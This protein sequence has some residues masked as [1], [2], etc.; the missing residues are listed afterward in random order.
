MIT[1][2]IFDLGAVVLS[3]DWHYDCQEKFDDF[4]ET[5]EIDYD[6]MERGWENHAHDYVKGKM[7]EEEFWERFLKT[8]G[9]KKI[10][11]EL[12]KK[13]YRKYQMENDNML[14]LL[15]RL[16]KY[17]LASLTTIG[18]EWLEFKREKFKVDNYFE[19]IV[20][21]PEFG[22]RKPNPRIYEI[23]LEKLKVLGEECVFIDNK[24]HLLPPAEKLGMK[25][26]H[27]INRKDCE[28]KLRELGIEF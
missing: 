20:S 11:I 23:T 15:K 26:I 21:S 22:M 5:F 17:R 12:A 8:A 16:R 13:I 9:A 24:Q 10:D 18:K 14:D 1:T 3:N 2:L 27:F 25:T 19:V 28:E 7:T 6:D 4:T